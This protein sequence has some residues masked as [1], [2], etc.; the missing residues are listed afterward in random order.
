MSAPEIISAAAQL[1]SV[2]IRWIHSIF[3]LV[4]PVWKALFAL[5]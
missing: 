2:F 1:Q 3:V 5:I 4:L